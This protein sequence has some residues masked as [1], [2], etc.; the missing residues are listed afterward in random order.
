[1]KSRVSKYHKN[2]LVNLVYLIRSSFL[3]K[4]YKLLPTPVKYNADENMLGLTKY[5]R[6]D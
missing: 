1:M 4:G 5:L 3:H 6:S 2:N